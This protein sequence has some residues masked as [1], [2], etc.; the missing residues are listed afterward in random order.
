MPCDSRSGRSAD[1]RKHQE[2]RRVE[3]AGRQDDLSGKRPVCAAF[4]AVLDA[5]RATALEQHAADQTV[6]DDAQIAARADRMQVSRGAAFPIAVADRE[7]RDAEALRIGAMEIIELTKTELLRGLNHH[8]INVRLLR[9]RTGHTQRPRSAV[10]ARPAAPVRLSPA[11][12]GQHAFV[13]P[14]R[15]PMR[16]QP[17]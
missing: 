11:E 7:V 2:L 8:R 1:A 9:I 17:S 14:S 4:R 6:L 13:V 12:I 5:R 16:A 3:S 10:K 15:Q